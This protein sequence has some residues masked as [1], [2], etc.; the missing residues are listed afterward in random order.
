MRTPLTG[1]AAAFAGIL[2]VGILFA[3]EVHAQT[4]TLDAPDLVNSPDSAG[5]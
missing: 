1:S 2:L 5:P 3:N 4:D